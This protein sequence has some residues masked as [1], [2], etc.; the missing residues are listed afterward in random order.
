MNDHRIG[1]KY[2]L[3][4]EMVRLCKER[5][6]YA[7][8]IAAVQSG[9]HVIQTKVPSNMLSWVGGSVFAASTI[10]LE[11]SDSAYQTTREAYEKNQKLP[12]WMRI[13]P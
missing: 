12:D 4:N 3:K 5:V 6:A 9:V 7:D 1:F 13:V 11:K 8:L 2:R 10:N